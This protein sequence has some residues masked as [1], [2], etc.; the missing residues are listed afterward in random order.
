MLSLSWNCFGI[1]LSPRSLTVAA[2]FDLP[3]LHGDRKVH[4]GF[5]C[6]A[7]AAADGGNQC[8]IRGR[9]DRDVRCSDRQAAGWIVAAPAAALQ[10]DLAP[11]VKVAVIAE[12]RVAFIAADEASRDAHSPAGGAEE[13][14]HIAARTLTLGQRAG[15]RIGSAVRP[16][17]LAHGL[18]QAAAQTAQECGSLPIHFDR[19]SASEFTNGR[20]VIGA[21]VRDQ[22]AAQ[23][24]CVLHRHVAIGIRQEIVEGILAQRLDL[25]TRAHAELLRQAL[26]PDVRDHV[27]VLIES[28][29]TAGRVRR[30]VESEGSEPLPT[31]VP[32][33]QTDDVRLEMDRA[34]VAIAGGVDYRETHA[35]NAASIHLPGRSDT[36]WRIR[37]CHQ[38]EIGRMSSRWYRFSTIS[39]L[40]LV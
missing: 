29:G 4:R 5:R 31:V 8:R 34:G 3:Y 9:R 24:F 6:T 16:L 17:D 32:R 13:H 1:A 14:R 7:V 33:A 10:I 27:A 28:V 38:S 20:I 23:R 39:K 30:D 37:S 19:D 15:G 22:R 18:K 36:L 11:G 25:K 40:S 21:H 12:G 26:E 2:L 35:G